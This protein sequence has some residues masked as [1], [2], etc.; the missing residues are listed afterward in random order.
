MYLVIAICKKNNQTIGVIVKVGEIYRFISTNQLVAKKRAYEKVLSNVIITKDGIVRA[1]QGNLDICKVEGNIIKSANKNINDLVIDKEGVLKNVK[2]KLLVYHGS[3]YE[4]V[5][6]KYGKGNDKHDYGNGFY[7]T[8]FEELAKEWAVCNSEKGYVH[9]FELDIKGLKIFDF[10][11]VSALNWLAEL[12]KHR[13]A[14]DSAR[15][16]R[17]APLFI[18]K[19]G[20]NIDNYDIIYGWRADSSY[21]HIAKRFMRNEID[22]DLINELFHLGDLENQV[23]LKSELAFK[24]WKLVNVKPVDYKEYN[25]KYYERDARARE[26]MKKIIESPRNTMQKGLDFVLSEGFKL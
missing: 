14:D 26:E 4:S 15:Y 3:P 23:C 20:I 8:E 11:K 10:N 13:D 17:Y 16:K 12:M 19:F 1:K 9:T 22:Y 25:T 24:K 21:F 2:T 5:S 7:L 18:E 6:P